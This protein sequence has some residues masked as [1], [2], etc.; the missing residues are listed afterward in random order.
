MHEEQPVAEGLGVVGP[1]ER[2]HAPA[3]DGNG[4]G[5]VSAN[6]ARAGVPG[7]VM[8][9]VP[10]DHYLAQ[11]SVEQKAAEGGQQD[12]S[13]LERDAILRS[14][15][16]LEGADRPLLYV[17]FGAAGASEALVELAAY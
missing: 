14:L 16:T 17:G 6:L 12:G 11:D 9:E 15:E 1:P 2:P 10:A 4:T 7:P 8:V 5:P 13:P 3:G